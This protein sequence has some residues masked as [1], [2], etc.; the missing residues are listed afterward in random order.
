M[1]DVSGCRRGEGGLAERPEGLRFAAR[2]V[3]REAGD[4][5]DG[6]DDGDDLRGAHHAR[7][8]RPRRQPPCR[9]HSQTPGAP[10]FSR[11]SESEMRLLPNMIL[12]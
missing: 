1:I 9:F 10:T 5:N 2:L 7:T 3:P 4:A 6:D 11:H 8:H 12:V